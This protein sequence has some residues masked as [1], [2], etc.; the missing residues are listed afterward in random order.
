MVG[1]VTQV[2]SWVIICST[3]SVLLVSVLVPRLAGATPFTIL[4]GSM[5]PGMP[6]GTLVVVKPTAVAEIS[7]GDVIT[8]Q[9]TSG[10]PT[11][12]THRVV[13]KGFDLSGNIT[14]TTKGDANDAED[15]KLVVP[16]QVR[17][18]RWYSIPHLG[19][20]VNVVKS[21]QRDVVGVVVAGLLAGYA[22]LMFV[23]SI[24]DRRSTDRPRKGAAS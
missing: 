24:R 6:P 12:V 10:E 9:L 8:Y 22:G 15:E 18:V 1:R 21:S 23:G 7:V 13:A 19:R 11:V 3:V 5:R 4:T 17:G 16:A 14:L 20:A 2:V